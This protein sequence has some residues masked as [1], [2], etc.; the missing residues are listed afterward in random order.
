MG[1]VERVLGR[2]SDI[3][4]DHGQELAVVTTALMWRDA[5]RLLSE[6]WTEDEVVAHMACMEEVKPDLPEDSALARMKR[7]RDQVNARL[8]KS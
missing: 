7:I 4:L 6:G 1:P 8:A 3:A 2:L 5:S